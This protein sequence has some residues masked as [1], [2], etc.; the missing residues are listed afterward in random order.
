MARQSVTARA[1]PAIPARSR[2]DGDSPRHWD[3]EHVRRSQK[4]LWHSG[5][6]NL[7]HIHKGFLCMDL[8]LCEEVPW[9]HSTY[10]VML[11]CSSITSSSAH[12]P[13]ANVFAGTHSVVLGAKT[14][15]TTSQVH[16]CQKHTSLQV[17]SPY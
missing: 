2:A 5:S 16:P 13:P 3:K 17:N 9:P 11:M 1:H 6:W 15:L 4:L 14:L 10:P 8:F 12:H 7:L